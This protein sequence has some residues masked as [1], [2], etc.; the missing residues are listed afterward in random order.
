LG[1]LQEHAFS[2]FRMCRDSRRGFSDRGNGISFASLE[3]FLNDMAHDFGHLAR[4]LLFL[5]AVQEISFF[6]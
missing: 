1:V 4:C 3:S 2:F 5:Q 6:I